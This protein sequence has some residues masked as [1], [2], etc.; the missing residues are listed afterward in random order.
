MSKHTDLLGFKVL[1][2][3]VVRKQI[4]QV[5]K[6]A[7]CRQ[8]SQ[9]LADS[10]SLEEL[11]SRLDQI[12]MDMEQEA[13]P[14]GGP[15]ADMYADEMDAY[16][17]ALRIAKGGSD[18]PM[19]Y[20]DMLKKHYPSK[21]EF[22]K[23]SKFD[24]GNWEDDFDKKYPSLKE[25]GNLNEHWLCNDNMSAAVCAQL[26][27]R[28]NR[29]RGRLGEG[30]WIGDSSYKTRVSIEGIGD[31]E[32]SIDNANTLDNVTIRWRGANHW[33]NKMFTGLNF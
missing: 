19:T 18:K 33:G 26:I 7:Q 10:Y 28:W 2:E 5:I 8:K 21:D 24:R 32:I 16:E 9:E 29:L 3:N 12:M 14:E 1:D 6:E 30:K 4:R 22:T 31:T 11:Q 23:S 27:D 15:I 17:G 20:D 25:E 13:E